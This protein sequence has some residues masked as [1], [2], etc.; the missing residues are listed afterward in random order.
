MMKNDEQKNALDKIKKKLAEMFIKKTAGAEIQ[1]IVKK[2]NAQVQKQKIKALRD[3]DIEFNSDEFSESDDNVQKK[4]KYNY[5]NDSDLES[6]MDDYKISEGESLNDSADLSR[7]SSED[8]Q[9][10]K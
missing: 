4:E 6:Q 8:D 2:K 3:G 9:D 7:E 10:H 5:Y 1:S